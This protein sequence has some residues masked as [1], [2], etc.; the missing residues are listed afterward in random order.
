[1]QTEHEH[2]VRRMFDRDVFAH[3]DVE[4]PSRLELPRSA[5]G[6]DRG[7]AQIVE[8]SVIDHA[9][10]S[11]DLDLELDRSRNVQSNACK[12]APGNAAL[13]LGEHIAIAQIGDGSLCE[14]GP[15]ACKTMFSGER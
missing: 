5:D 12:S 1:M 6:E 4:I 2:N 8:I 15:A 11:I 13:L 9:G 3:A 10:V 7:V 14:C